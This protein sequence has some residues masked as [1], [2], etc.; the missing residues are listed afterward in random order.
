MT[1]NPDAPLWENSLQQFRN[2]VAAGTPTPG[3][4]AVAAV[5]ATLAA[6]LLQM[7]CTISD[8]R[9]ADEGM[10]AIAASVEICGE[11]LARCAEEDIR[12][13][14]RYLAVRKLGDRSAK[15]ELQR[16]LLACSEVPLVAAEAVAKLQAL[17]PKL[18][19]DCPEFL[20]SELAA[21]RYL[22]DASRKGLL[23]SVRANLA[24]LQDG[25]AKR[26]ALLRLDIVQNSAEKERVKVRS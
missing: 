21:A 22:L 13:F 12:V 10:S 25:D 2:R 4:G 11:E 23:S 20:L 1:G 5:A 9:K 24:E 3:G 8:R 26:A 16:C 17:A 6:A 14:D 19:L 15:A 18:E 7:V